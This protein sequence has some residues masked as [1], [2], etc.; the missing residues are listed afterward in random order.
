MDDFQYLLS[1]YMSLLM[2]YSMRDVSKLSPEF[3]P[4][5]SMEGL[6][7]DSLDYLEDGV[8]CRG[9]KTSIGSASRVCRG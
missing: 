4:V 5:L 7:P 6:D 2:S 9:A 3:F 8:F 1:R